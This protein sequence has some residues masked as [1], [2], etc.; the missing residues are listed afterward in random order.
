M[1]C[2][3]NNNSF[4]E[5]VLTS[6]PDNFYKFLTENQNIIMNKTSLVENHF[7][8]LYK[9]SFIFSSLQKTNTLNS[10]YHFM[11]PYILSYVSKMCNK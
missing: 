1:S 2:F 9:Y 3:V 5:C 6:N 11:Y 8:K 7:K 10:M 4:T